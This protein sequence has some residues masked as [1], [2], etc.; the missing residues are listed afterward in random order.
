MIEAPPLLKV[1]KH[2]A[3]LPL[4][5]LRRFKMCQQA[6]LWMRAAGAV[7][8]LWLS[9]SKQ[10]S[11]LAAFLSLALPLPLKMPLP[12]Y[13]PLLRLFITPE[14]AIFWSLDLLAIKAVPEQETGFAGC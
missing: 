1:K 2:A 11:R 9:A 7:R 13:W 10:P 14:R 8:L 12:M 3:A 4:F 5:K 6:R